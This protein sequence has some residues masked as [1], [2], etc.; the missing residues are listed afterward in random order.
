MYLMHPRLHSAKKKRDMNNRDH[1]SGNW[2]LGRCGSVRFGSVR[3]VYI[4]PEE[5][6]TCWEE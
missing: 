1:G 2:E 3:L 6:W 5:E 4:P